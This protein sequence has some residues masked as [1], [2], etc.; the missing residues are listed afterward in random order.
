MEPLHGL[1]TARWTLSTL[2]TIIP[3]AELSQKYSK[4]PSQMKRLIRKNLN[5]PS[6]VVPL[7]LWSSQLLRQQ[8]R[9]N[10]CFAINFHYRQDHSKYSEFHTKT[11]HKD[12]ELTVVYCKVGASTCQ[13]HRHLE[14]WE[15]QIFLQ[16]HPIQNH[17]LTRQC[18]H[19]LRI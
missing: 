17:N 16:I 5:H 19:S 7:G 1:K 14:N 10:P 4:R 18:V 6:E 13:K 11:V 15:M 12:P 3:S 2:L 9:E 8:N